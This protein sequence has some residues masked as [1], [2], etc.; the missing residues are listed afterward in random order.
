MTE[1][2]RH[3]VLDKCFEHN[4]HQGTN[5]HLVAEVPFQPPEDRRDPVLEKRQSRDD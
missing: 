5:G 2:E 4:D 1:D 3:A